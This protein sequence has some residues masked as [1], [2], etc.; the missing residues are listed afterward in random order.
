MTGSPSRRTVVSGASL[1]AG[2]VALLVPTVLPNSDPGGEALDTAA[3]GGVGGD[4]QSF[5][6]QLAPLLLLPGVVALSGQ[7]RGRGAG[8][9]MS[10]A[11]VYGAGLFGFF[12]FA[13]LASAESALAGPVPVDQVLVHG[14]QRIE[15]SAA[16][17]PS[18][19]LALLFF[20]LLGLPWLSWGL[21]RAGLTTWWVATLATVGTLAA[22]F[23]T[24]TA[25]EPVGWVGVSLSLGLLAMPLLGVRGVQSLDR[26]GEPVGV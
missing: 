26:E 17:V 23:G 9:T 10:G 4:V 11:V 15:S 22:F 20:H 18:L 8:L 25:V 5:L 6:L 21:V 24:G 2:A 19:L 13:V 12:T 3:G 7:V 1:I 14:A 16:V